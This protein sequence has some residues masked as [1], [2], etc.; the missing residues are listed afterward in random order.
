MHDRAQLFALLLRARVNRNQRNLF[1]DNP[2]Q[3]ALHLGIADG[4]DEAVVF[5][6]RGPIDQMHHARHVAIRRMAVIDR[7]IEILACLLDRVLD[8]VPPS[9]RIRR[10]AD[11]NES[12]AGGKGR[13]RPSQ[14]GCH[15]Q[16]KQHFYGCFGHPRI[17]LSALRHRNLPKPDNS[18]TSGHSPIAKTTELVFIRARRI[19]KPEAGNYQ[20]ILNYL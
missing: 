3:R 19:S 10:M 20:Q 7:D 15:D 9:I 6:R 1:R 18:P 13:C 5:L 2:L 4:R 16:S 17:S 14:G 11:Q 12:P 8:R